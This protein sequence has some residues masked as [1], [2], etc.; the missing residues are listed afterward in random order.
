MEGWLYPCQCRVPHGILGAREAL[1]PHVKG[2][3]GARGVWIVGAV[4]GWLMRH[5]RPMVGRALKARLGLRYCSSWCAK[6]MGFGPGWGPGALLTSGGSFL[7]ARLCCPSTLGGTHSLSGVCP[8]ADLSSGICGACAPI[9]EALSLRGLGHSGW[10]RLTCIVI[11]VGWLHRNGAVWVRQS[12]GWV[13]VSRRPGGYGR[14]S[15]SVSWSVCLSVCHSLV[16]WAVGVCVS[17]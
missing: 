14:L 12:S 13:G 17:W 11:P 6:G 7:G 5:T 10:G 1:S 15:V 4:G 2:C 3:P 8:P 16:C 9:A